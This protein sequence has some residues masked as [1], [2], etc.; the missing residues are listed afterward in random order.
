[1]EDVFI[2]DQALHKGKK[3]GF[4]HLVGSSAKLYRGSPRLEAYEGVGPERRPKQATIDPLNQDQ[5]ILRFYTKP[6]KR[7]L[8]NIEPFV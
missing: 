4:V 6:C 7:M 2:E 1:M 5:N 3:R 8:K